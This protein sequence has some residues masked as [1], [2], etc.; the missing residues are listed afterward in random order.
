MLWR[1]AVAIRVGAGLRA[2]PLIAAAFLSAA[3]LALA[4]VPW[5]L[6]RIDQR[7]LPLDGR[8]ARSGDAAG[9]HAYIVD[10]GVRKSHLDF[11][12]RVEWV[13][14]FVGGNPASQDAADCDVP[15]LHGHGTHV[16]SILGGREF[17]VAPGVRLHAL[18]ILPCTG[19]TRTDFE[20]AIRAVEWI[21]AHG[22]K[23]AVV[24]ISPAR[25]QTADTR[26]D[27]AIRRSSAAGFVYVLSAGGIADIS[28]YTPQRVSEAITVASTDR[29]DRAANQQYGPLLTLFAP[30]VA[31]EAAGNASDTGTFTGDGDSYAAPFAAGVAALYLAAHARATPAA[32]KA[33]LVASATRG[34]VRG[35]GDSPNLLLHL[36]K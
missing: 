9:V 30:G 31:I 26:L 19:T 8:F 16:A 23:P 10:T 32:V 11:G 14:D 34:V 22:V 35:A 29:D 4:A 36:A 33:A 18:R 21:T 25:W 17:G 27:A 24:N 6:D 12:G 3:C 5:G 20:A 13:G 1:L 7:A 28:Q 2:G 15:D